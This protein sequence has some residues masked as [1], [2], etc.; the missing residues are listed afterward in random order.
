MH[1]FKITTT[2]QV[3]VQAY[4]WIPESKPAAVLQ[5]VHGM[6]E[7]ARRYDHFARWLNK[8][9]IAVYAEDHI[10]HGLTASDENELA[11]FPRKDDWHRQVDILHHLTLKIKSDFPGLPVFVL[12]HSM[13]SVLTQTYMIRYGIE[14]DGYILSG[15]IRQSLFMALAGRMLARIL[16]A[17][18]GPANRSRLLVTLGYGQ[19]NKHFKPTRTKVDWL[20]SVDAVVD[21]Y[22][23][24]PLCGKRLTN[25]FYENLTYGFGFITRP[26]NLGKIPGLKPV[27]TIAGQDDPAGFFGKAPRKIKQ[28]LEK[29]AQAN[30]NLRLYPEGRHEILNEINREEVYSDILGWMQR[31]APPSFHFEH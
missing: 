19:Y 14:A 21:E 5:I 23:S 13:G 25:R 7:H 15:A 18:S 26:K 11:H 3:T 2:D 10:G 8:H 16:S 28:L 27:F 9:G 6:Q 22:L 31:T 29:Y 30:V 12:G 17:L 24:S 20:C 4:S 1:S